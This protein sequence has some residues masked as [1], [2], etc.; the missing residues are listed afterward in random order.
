[1]TI[2][3]DPQSG[4]PATPNC[5]QQR[6]EVFIAGTEPVGFCPLHGGGAGQST[7]SG[8]DVPGT[9]PQAGSGPMRPPDP[10]AALRRNDG[11]V[12]PPPVSYQN[13]N[14]PSVPPNPQTEPQQKKKGFFGKLK[15]VF[16]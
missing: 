10:A 13:P 16:K 15:D 3:I 8:W 11:S 12:L 5:P 1:M 7:V 4:M 9:Q 14:N 2:T 6:P